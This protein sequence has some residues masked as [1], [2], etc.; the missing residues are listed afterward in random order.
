MEKIMLFFP[1]IFLLYFPRIEGQVEGDGKC[2]DIPV[3]QNFNIDSYMGKWYQHASYPS[4]IDLPSTCHNAEYTLLPNGVILVGN[5]KTFYPSMKKK[6][7]K[8][9]LKQVPG[10]NEGKF[11]INFPF[12]RVNRETPYWVLET[13]YHSYAVVWS[14]RENINNGKLTNT[15]YLWFLTRSEDLLLDTLDALYDAIGKSP[16]I[17]Q[18]EI[19]LSDHYKCNTTS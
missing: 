1:V 11:L 3:Q 4:K 14:C 5:S 6:T 9:T 7:I 12:K 16:E 15:R 8:G 2:P 19:E 10:E 13:D 18:Y 17:S